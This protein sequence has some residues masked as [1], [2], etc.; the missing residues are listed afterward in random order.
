VGG[1]A[2]N[3]TWTALRGRML[4]VPM[5]PARSEEAAVGTAGLALRA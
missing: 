2:R 1:G 4:G 3:P 5:L